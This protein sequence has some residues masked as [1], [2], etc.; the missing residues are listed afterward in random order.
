MSVQCNTYI[1]W[2][3]VFPFKEFRERYDDFELY[4]DSAF[5]GI[6]HHNGLC[7]LYD[8]M[9]AKYFAIGHVLHKTENYEGFESPVALLG[10][11]VLDFNVF[12]RIQEVIGRQ[13]TN[14]EHVGWLVISHYR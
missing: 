3:A 11:P 6:H 12:Q 2:G 1:M 7:V 8:G 13:L 10:Q 14:D 9:N 4:Q 5:K